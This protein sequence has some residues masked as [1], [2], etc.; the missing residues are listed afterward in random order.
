MK[1]KGNNKMSRPKI[2]ISTI[3]GVRL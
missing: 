2:D 3:L 1:A